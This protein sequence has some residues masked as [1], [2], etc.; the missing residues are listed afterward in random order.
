M[1]MRSAMCVLIAA[2]LVAAFVF[3]VSGKRIVSSASRTP[4][5]TKTWNGGSL[6]YWNVAGNWIPS[7]IPGAG[8]D[9]IIGVGNTVTYTGA[10]STVSSIDCDG[11][12]I[13]AGGALAVTNASSLNSLE[14]RGASAFNSDTSVTAFQLWGN[15][16][17]EGVLG[18]SGTITFTDQFYWYGA[19]S[20]LH[21]QRANARIIGPGKIV[22]ASS[23]TGAGMVSSYDTTAGEATLGGTDPGTGRTLEIYGRLVQN[24]CLH[25][26][27]NSLIDIRPGGWIERGGTCWIGG[28]G[29][30]TNNGRFEI[31]STGSIQVPFTNNG[32]IDVRDYGQVS[33]Y[34]LTNNGTLRG[35]PDSYIQLLGYQSEE[36]GLTMP[37]GSIVTVTRGTVAFVEGFWNVQGTYNVGTT[38]LDNQANVITMTTAANLQMTNLDV[39]S[40]KLV[41]QKNVTLNNLKLQQKYEYE[42]PSILSG[43]GNITING[44]FNWS[45]TYSGGLMEGP[46]S[47]TVNGTV[48]INGAGI[49][50]TGSPGKPRNLYLNGAGTWSGGDVDASSGSP[51]TLNASHSLT[52]KGVLTGTLTN[53][54]SLSVGGSAGTLKVTNGYTQGATGALNMELGG[55]NPGEYDLLQ[56]S[57]TAALAGTLNVSEINGYALAGNS[58]DILTYE[59]RSGS[60]N[61]LNLPPGGQVTYNAHALNVSGSGSAPTSVSISGASNGTINLSYPFTATVLPVGVSP[62]PSYVWSPTPASGQGTASAKYSWSIT[63][64]KT[65]TVTASNTLGSVADTHEINIVDT[66]ITGLKAVNNQSASIRRDHNADRNHRWRD[67][68]DLPMGFWRW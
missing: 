44:L 24:G 61:T 52:A 28:A 63:G 47:T 46:G 36:F 39:E 6:G 12:L 51:I 18:G 16:T 5:A 2:F 31:Y 38:I 58:L 9:V 53:N 33:L 25:L 26:A 67:K 42:H 45:G 29:T 22:I 8:D 15:A 21:G 64:N 14:V 20:P 34:Y 30:I 4:T 32:M 19:S 13:V 11:S 23:I 48:N 37:P 50:S 35:I 10:T 60:F 27:S 17:V 43:N 62:A 65:I 1:K 40:G 41:L 55:N 3:L 59:S 66:A 68:C 56:I 54:G 57:G 7:G 49:K